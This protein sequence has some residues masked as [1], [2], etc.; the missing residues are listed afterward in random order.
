MNVNNL[1]DIS[2]YMVVGSCGTG[3]TVLCHELKK[4]LKRDIETLDDFSFKVSKLTNTDRTNPLFYLMDRV[5]KMR[6]EKNPIIATSHYSR[7]FN[8]VIQ[9][10]DVPFITKDNPKFAIILTDLVEEEYYNFPVHI[11]KKI[12]IKFR[13]ANRRSMQGKNK[14]RPYLVITQDKEYRMGW[15]R[16]TRNLNTKIEKNEG[17]K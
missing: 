16:D 11:P 10:L 13:N 2:L 1:K 14:T 9:L 4:S 5:S 7:V 8:K 15:F 12:A 3:K 17:L 6:H